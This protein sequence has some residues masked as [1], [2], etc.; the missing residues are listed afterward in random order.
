MEGSSP[1]GAVGGLT[2]LPRVLQ[3]FTLEERK[4]ERRLH[5]DE[6]FL[7]VRQKDTELTEE[8]RR[9]GGAGAR[10]SLSPRVPELH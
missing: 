10:P 3:C 2:G 9:V 5:P 7:R 6:S 4:R 1:P 8:E